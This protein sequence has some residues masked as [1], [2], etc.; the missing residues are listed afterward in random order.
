[1]NPLRC[2]VRRKTVPAQS[3]LVCVRQ[4]DFGFG[5]PLAA[6]RMFRVAF[7]HASNL[8]PVS[9]QGSSCL[10][11]GYHRSFAILTKTVV[12]KQISL[13]CPHAV[14]VACS[15]S[16]TDDIMCSLSPRMQLDDDEVCRKPRV[17]L[18]GPDALAH[19]PA[20]DRSSASRLCTDHF[21]NRPGGPRCTGR[22][23][24]GFQHLCHLQV[25]P[26]L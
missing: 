20:A 14:P 10:S 24:F 17:S 7:G 19:P 6:R 21:G 25:F 15:S 5:A 1:M 2:A 3:T 22:D 23:N 13:P 11:G 26:M 12:S 4:S 9:V 8:L 16:E 18:S